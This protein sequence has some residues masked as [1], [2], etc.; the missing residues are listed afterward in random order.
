VAWPEQN[1][2]EG[3]SSRGSRAS[4]PFGGTA[5]VITGTGPANASAVRF[6]MFY[7][8]MPDPALMTIIPDS[9]PTAGG[10][11]VTI[12]GTVTVTSATPITATTPLHTAGAAS[13]TPGGTSSGLPYDYLPKPE[14]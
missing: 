5:V 6:E 11:P 3:G 1:F 2:P 7:A 10:T 14:I 8:Y 12:S 9:G 4:S 13:A